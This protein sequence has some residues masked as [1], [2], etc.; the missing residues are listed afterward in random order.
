MFKI[1][2]LYQNKKI[3]IFYC[4]TKC[5]DNFFFFLRYIWSYLKFITYIYHSYLKSMTNYNRNV[6]KKV[7]VAIANHK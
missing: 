5:V 2:L 7:M 3:K 6:Y 1:S 4:N